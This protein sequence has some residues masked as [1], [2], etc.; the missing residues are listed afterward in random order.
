M[1]E[2]LCQPSDVAAQWPKFG[3]LPYV[4]GPDGK[5]KLSKRDGAKDILDYKKEGYLPEAMVSFLATL[6]WND[7][8]EQ[9]IFTVSELKQKFSLSKVHRAGAHFD[10]QRLIWMNGH[11]I[12]QKSLDELYEFSK[13]FWPA[14]AENAS[15][16]YK[17]EVLGLVQERLKFLAE[18]PDAL[19]ARQVDGIRNASEAAHRSHHARD[20][21]SRHANRPPLRRP[22]CQQ[23]ARRLQVHRRGAAPT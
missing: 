20:H 11:Y 12:R 17:K 2:L 5:K 9:E 14:S 3:T 16:E 4:L 21:E 1:S 18:L 22:N 7:G 13:D 10:E 15:E 23:S 8:T 19:Q 6:G